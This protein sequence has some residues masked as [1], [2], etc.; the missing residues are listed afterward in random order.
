MLQ[1]VFTG[2]A[3]ELDGQLGKDVGG[4]SGSTLAVLEDVATGK[5]VLSLK[6]PKQAGNIGA[7]APDGRVLLTHSHQDERQI[8]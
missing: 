5:V 7:F 4:H 2:G 3:G 6:L 8:H 1:L